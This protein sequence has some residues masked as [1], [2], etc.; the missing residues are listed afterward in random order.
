L[1]VEVPRPRLSV[2]LNL[3]PRI[4]YGRMTCEAISTL[5]FRISGTVS[6]QR[7]NL[8]ATAEAGYNNQAQFRLGRRKTPAI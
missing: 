1:L 7:Q 3:D 2:L 8:L 5:A 4:A 6:G